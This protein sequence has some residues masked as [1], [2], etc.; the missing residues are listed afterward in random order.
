MA[1][2]D[3]KCGLLNRQWRIAAEI[4]PAL[5]FTLLTQYEAWVGP[6][7]FIGGSVIGPKALVSAVLALVSVGLLLRLRYPLVALALTMTPFGFVHV[8][9]YVFGPVNP[10]LFEVFLSQVF[11]VYSTAANTAGRRTYVGAALI[12]SMQLT[13]YGPMLPGSLT[14]AFG[15]WVFYAIAWVLGKTLRGRI[16]RTDRLEARTAELEAQREHQI[17]L[18]VADERARIARELHDVVAHSVSLM[19]LQ[20]GAARQALDRNPDKARE[21]MLSVEA[22]GRSAMSE[23]RR[24][25]TMLRQPGE[26]DELAPQP[27]LRHLDLLIASM[28][29]AGLTIALDVDEHLE[30]I[31]PGVD[32][33]AY[34]IVQEALTNVLKHAG[35]T[36]VDVKV[37]RLTGAIEVSVE[38][39][40]RG[41]AGNGA[42]AGGHGLIGMKERVNLFGGSLEAAGRDGGGFR[43]HARLPY[44]A[45]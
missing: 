30:G 27:S 16:L 23:L 24:L 3:L 4:G 37:V 32:L 9:H 22:T 42:L 13:A 28:R 45:A 26:E 6:I 44:D 36:H 19:V 41:S 7:S 21:P 15:E 18:A 5:A 31:P 20:A 34:R 38:D 11:I 12:I 29:E 43:V 25:V 40:G 17:Q 10:N 2:G 14:Q 8:I 1:A 33:S 35:A 39:N